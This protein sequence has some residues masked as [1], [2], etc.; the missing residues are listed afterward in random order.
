MI[1][2]KTWIEDWAKKYDDEYNKKERLQE[3]TIFESIKKIES[4]PSYLTKE[5]VW[6]IAEWKAARVKGHVNK[7]DDQ[8]IKDV[9]QVSLTTKNERLRLEVLTLLNGVKIRM[10]SAILFFCYPK[11][12]TVMDYRAWNSL[13][14]LGKIDGQIDDTFEGWQKYNEVCKEIAQQNS[15][16]LRTLDKALWKYNGGAKQ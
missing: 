8:F 1:L 13:K 14:E 15:V 6:K 10:A 5:I 11:R 2:N 12:Y 16:S 9:T 3:I 4:P 7:N